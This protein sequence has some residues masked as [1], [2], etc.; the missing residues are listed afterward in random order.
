M[1]STH[2]I[3]NLKDQALA[4]A[5]HGVPVFPCIP[6]GKAPLTRN[7]FHDA[8]TDRSVVAAWWSM[9]PNANIA[10]PTGAPGIDV[11]DVDVRPDG[12]GW[13]AFNAAQRAGLLDGWL[14][15]VETPSGGL[16]LHYPGTEQR[17]GSIRGQ[18][19]DF[20]GAGG[21]VLLPP[22]LGQT[23]TYSR[24]YVVV[25]TR[26]RARRA[27]R[28][29]GAHRTAPTARP[30]Q[31][32]RRTGP[33]RGRVEWLAAHVAR[34]AEGNRD[35]ALFWAAC[36]AAETPDLDPAPL[37][38]AAVQAG[39]TE[40]EARRTVRSAYQ[41]VARDSVAR[42][43]ASATA[44]H[45]A[46]DEPM[47]TWPPTRCIADAADPSPTSPASWAAAATPS[48]RCSPAAPCP[49]CGSAA[50]CAASGAATSRRSSPA[51]RTAGPRTPRPPRRTR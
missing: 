17:N 7:G 20:R 29:G 32:S 4:Y 9:N 1:A 41:R 46:R 27:A 50:G 19:L 47:S 11:L 23:K 5:G 16:H 39:L 24:R 14:R 35:N 40:R 43:A 13:S 21:Y 31:A 44:S 22:S 26:P 48:T 6:G 10:T 37:I 8:S 30:S 49:P 38:A 45:R 28:L 25:R 2:A 18:H 33:A 36:R 15:A 51:W 3:P 42:A 34:Q 12:S